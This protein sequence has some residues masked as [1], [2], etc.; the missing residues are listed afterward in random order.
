MI[1]LWCTLIAVLFHYF[2]WQWMVIPW[3]P[4]AL[5]G[6]A[7]A[8]LVGFKKQSGIRQIVGGQK[9]M[10]RSCKFKQISWINGLCI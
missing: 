1:S 5:I 9:N 2:N 7:E 10:G 8:F 3:V 6:T 4:V